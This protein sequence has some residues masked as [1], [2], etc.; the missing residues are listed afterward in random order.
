V[1]FAGH[2]RNQIDVFIFSWRV[3]SVSIIVG[4][5]KW[6]LSREGGGVIQILETTHVGIALEG[7]C[8]F[9]F[10]SGMGLLDFPSLG[11]AL[12]YPQAGCNRC[13]FSENI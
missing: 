8:N 6:P 2:C 12:R 13:E 5:P 3:L 7:F 9:M 10:N 11:F 1:D 4:E